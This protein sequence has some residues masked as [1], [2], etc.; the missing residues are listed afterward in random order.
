MRAL[1]SRGS[2]WEC[3]WIL[4]CSGAPYSLDHTALWLLLGHSP[5]IFS[6]SGTFACLFDFSALRV[7]LRGEFLVHWACRTPLCSPKDTPENL[8]RMNRLAWTFQPKNSNMAF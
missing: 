4:R 3:L 8:E 1:S 7:P 6:S 2:V 5:W